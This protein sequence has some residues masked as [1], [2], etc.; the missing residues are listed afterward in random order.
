VEDAGEEFVREWSHVGE[1]LQTCGGLETAV[2]KVY[3]EQ[4]LPFRAPPMRGP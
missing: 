4:Q 2:R 3:D 1:Y